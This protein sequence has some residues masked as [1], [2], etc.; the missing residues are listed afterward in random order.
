V[1]ILHNYR[2]KDAPLTQHLD[3]ISSTPFRVA[4]YKQLREQLPKDCNSLKQRHLVES[5]QSP[6]EPRLSSPSTTPEAHPN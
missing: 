1:F 6:L 4:S 3:E 5:K 2:C